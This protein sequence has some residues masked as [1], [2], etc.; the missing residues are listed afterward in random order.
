MNQPT[1]GI[2]P[3]DFKAAAIRMLQRTI[4]DNLGAHKRNRKTERPRRT[5]EGERPGQL[6][7]GNVIAQPLG[8]VLAVVDDL[9]HQVG[10]GRTV[11]QGNQAHLDGPRLGDVQ[12]AMRSQR[13]GARNPQIL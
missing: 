7:E 11:E 2:I 8:L 1:G 5:V 10:R 3:Q 6:H 12:A 13:G 4:T 9:F